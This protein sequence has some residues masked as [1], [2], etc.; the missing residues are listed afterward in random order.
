VLSVEALSESDSS[1]SSAELSI[2][3]RSLKIP[4]GLKVGDYAELNESGLF[5][6][7]D[8]DGI[9]LSRSQAESAIPLL[10][11]GENV[12][13]IRVAQAAAAELTLISMGKVD[14][15]NP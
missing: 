3:N 9:E 8:H 5:R 7:F 6:V 4:V 2:G 11:S 10:D 13:Q 15:H 12:I 14:I 1:F